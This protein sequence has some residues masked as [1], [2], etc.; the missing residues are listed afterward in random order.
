MWEFFTPTRYII[1]L[2]KIL[3]GVPVKAALVWSA[4]LEQH[5]AS[6]LITVNVLFGHLFES[7]T[8]TKISKVIIG[9]TEV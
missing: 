3:L 2:F 9:L 5:V 6:I 4:N 7:S 1:K 8:T